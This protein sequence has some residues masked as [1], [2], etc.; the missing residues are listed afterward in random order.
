MLVAILPLDAILFYNLYS[1]RVDKEREVH[2]EAFRI[3]QMAA[4]E[5]Q[6]APN[7]LKRVSFHMVP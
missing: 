5:M 2:A 1:I 4:L 6:P 3:G 7:F